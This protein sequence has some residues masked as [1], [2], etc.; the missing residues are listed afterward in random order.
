MT[1]AGG[2]CHCFCSGTSPLSVSFRLT[3]RLAIGFSTASPPLTNPDPPISVLF[4]FFLTLAGTASG[5]A[6]Q[7]EGIGFGHDRSISIAHAILL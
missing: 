5:R 2:R 6:S 3:R 4:P 1:K 7:S